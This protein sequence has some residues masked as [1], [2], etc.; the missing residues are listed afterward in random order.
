M[1]GLDGCV[2]LC[3]CERECV[4]VCVN[5]SR[6]IHPITR[7]GLAGQGVCIGCS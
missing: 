6:L 2:I 1:C 5:V 7:V 4:C 3:V